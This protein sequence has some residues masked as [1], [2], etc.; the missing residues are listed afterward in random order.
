MA[1][2][3]DHERILDYWVR[4][5]HGLSETEW[6]DFYRLVSGVLVR[7]RLAP[8][9]ANPT[10]R[11]ELIHAFFAERVLLNAKTTKA[12]NLENVHALHKWLK[13]FAGDLAELEGRYESLP[14]LELPE[15]TDDEVSGEASDG[16]ELSALQRLH[17]AGIDSARVVA[18]ADDF[19]GALDPLEQ[20]YLS[21]NTCEEGKARQPISAIAARLKASSYHYRA[22][23]LGI[24]LSKG[25]GYAGYEE[26]KIGRWLS[27]LGA[28]MAP[29][30]RE[31]IA[32]LLSVL[33]Q[34]VRHW[35]E[36]AA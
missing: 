34:R 33:C 24:T 19:V 9:Y 18:S 5:K 17:E 25:D 26:T 10:A 36:R 23:L 11:Q 28:S 4:R 31:E 27:S 6:V 32:I 30:W 13:R 35:K 21:E 7:T 1:D 22:K 2:S 20:A 15:D 14:D 3:G 29:H 12:R 8:Q 16:L